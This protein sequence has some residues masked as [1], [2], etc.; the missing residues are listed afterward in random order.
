MPGKGVPLCWTLFLVS[1]PGTR[2][3]QLLPANKEKGPGRLSFSISRLQEWVGEASDRAQDRG[4]H[5]EEE[6]AGKRSLGTEVQDGLA[7]KGK[8]AESDEA[9][10]ARVKAEADPC[11]PHQVLPGSFT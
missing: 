8:M 7:G 6:R 5:P 4:I 3:P 2:P 9:H 11:V 1:H 10:R